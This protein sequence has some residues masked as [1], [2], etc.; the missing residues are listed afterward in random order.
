MRCFIS[1]IALNLQVKN[2]LT[3]SARRNGLASCNA[4]QP[5]DAVFRSS[6]GEPQMYVRFHSDSDPLTGRGFQARYR[7]GKFTPEMIQVTFY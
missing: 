5:K 1:S 2:G 6:S 3:E 7:V 4:R